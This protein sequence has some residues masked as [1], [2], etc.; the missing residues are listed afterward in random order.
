MLRAR[1]Q[2]GSAAIPAVLAALEAHGVRATSVML[3]R[4]SLDHVCLR[5]AGRA[6][7]QASSEH[8]EVAA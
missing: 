7:D 6:F 8:E 1:A 2:H 4:P 3:A 5:H